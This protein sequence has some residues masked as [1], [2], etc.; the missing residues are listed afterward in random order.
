MSIFY[1]TFAWQT[2]PKHL[3]NKVEVIYIKGGSEKDTF[4]SIYN[5]GI[6][7]IYINKVYNRKQWNKKII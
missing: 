5:K 3:Y 2:N 7:Y 6:F 4:L 1:C